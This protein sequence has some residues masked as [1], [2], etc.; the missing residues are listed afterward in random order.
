M[1]RIFFRSLFVLLLPV[2]AFAQSRGS[3]LSTMENDYF[4]IVGL[5]SRSV[6]YINELTL[7][8]VDQSSN[9]LMHGKGVFPQ[10]ILVALR[11]E[12]NVDFEGPYRIRVGDQGFVSLDFRWEAEL[13][14]LQTCQALTEA[15]LTRYVLY[16]YGPDAPAKMYAW[17]A[18]ALGL[19]CYLRF[20]PAQLLGL[21]DAGKR[22]EATQVD[23]LLGKKS[24]E[25]TSETFN[26]DSY[27]LLTALSQGGLGRPAVKELIEMSCSGADVT[28]ALE[29]YAAQTSG[30]S[31][32]PLGLQDWWQLQRQAIVETN[33]ELFEP[34]EVSQQWIGEMADFD[35]YRAEGGEL[36]N[37]RALW[38]HRDE[39]AL[40]S[41]LQA[42]HDLISLRL[43]EV[44]PAYF[45]AARSLG[46]LY[47][48]VLDDEP[49][50]VFLHAFAV[51]LSD[52]EDA[53]QLQDKT[54]K[55][56]DSYRR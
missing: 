49:A 27:F 56:L 15:Y 48:T 32:E 33:Y 10:R 31:D 28:G 8:L 16:Y 47:E 55:V 40:R 38:Q 41:I 23:T 53:K 26:D 14:L 6:S 25:T 42:R 19:G 11:P 37:L 3:K 4:E 12:A 54:Q 17:P 34:M 44:N 7:D 24:V 1:R 50:H 2:F 43:Q 13:T 51:Y 21:L 36:K 18:R 20:R 9:Y 5:D 52:F 30:P 39:E 35:V 45:N 29:T 22:S 46:A